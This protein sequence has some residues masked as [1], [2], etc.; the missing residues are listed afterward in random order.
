MV[1]NGG[2]WIPAKAGKRCHAAHPGGECWQGGGGEG[3]EWQQPRHLSRGWLGHHGC[4]SCGCVVWPQ[5]AELASHFLFTDAAGYHN[6]GNDQ[7]E[8]K[9]GQPGAQG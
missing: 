7:E 5:K 3:V 2:K 4:R 6:E 9:D 1:G 8:D